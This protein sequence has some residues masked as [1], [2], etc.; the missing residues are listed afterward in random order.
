[1]PGRMEIDLVDAVAEAVVSAEHRHVLVG[2]LAPAQRFAA[3]LLAEAAHALLC[4]SAAL[5]AERLDQH[6]VVIEQVVALEWRRLVQHLV[7][8][9]HSGTLL[10]SLVSSTADPVTA[11]MQRTQEAC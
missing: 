10:C 11:H 1:M 8:D 9:R 6:A 5:A 2:L 4:P 3:H 7:G